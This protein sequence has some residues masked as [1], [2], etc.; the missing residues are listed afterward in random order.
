MPEG[1][2][3]QQLIAAAWAAG[4]EARESELICRRRSSPAQREAE[5][6]KTMRRIVGSLQESARRTTQPE[7]ASL[8]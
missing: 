7:A 2:D 6:A 5:I 1:T 4:Y 3:I 8:H